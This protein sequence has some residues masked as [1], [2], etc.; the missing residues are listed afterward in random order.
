[1]SWIN[2]S[3]VYYVSVET[4]NKL[5]F[6]T[7]LSKTQ[8]I[9]KVVEKNNLSE[10]VTLHLHTNKVIEKRTKVLAPGLLRIESEPINTYFKNNRS[11]HRDY[12][13]VIKEHVETLQDLLKH[14]RALNSTY[15]N[16]YYAC[17]FV[18]R[19]QELLVY[20]SASCPFSQNGNEKWAPRTSLKKNNKPYVDTSGINKTV[21][22]NTQQSVEKQTTQKTGNTF[23]TST[24]RVSYTN[25]SGLQP[26]RNTKNDGIPRPSS[27]SEKNKVEAQHRESKSHGSNLYIISLNDMMKSSPI[28]LLSK[29]SK[30]KFWLWHHRLSR[31]NFD[32]INQLAKE[33]RVRARTPQQNGV[34]KRRNRTLVEAA[35][36]MLIFSKSLLFLWAEVVVTACYTQN[37]SLIH[38]RYNK[39]L[40]E[41][42]RERKPYLKYLHVFGALC[43]PTNDS[44]DLSKLKPEADAG[45]FI[46]YSPSTKAYRIYNKRTQMIME[47]I[48]TAS[49]SAKPP[50]K[51]D[52]DLPMFDEYFKHSPSAVSTTV[53]AATLLPPDTA[54]ASS[55]TTIDQDSLSLSATPITKTTVTPLHSTNVNEPN[56]KDAKF[57]SDTF[58]NPFA[59]SVTN[60]VESSS[61]IVDTSNMH[62]FQQ[63]QTYIRRWT[64]DHPLVTIIGQ[65]F[66]LNK[67]S[68]V[69][70]KPHTPRSCLRWKPT[71]RIFKTVGL[72]WI[73]TGKMF[74]DSTT[75]V[76]SEPPNG[77]N[78]D[79]SNPYE[80]DQTFYFSACTFNSS[81]DT[82]VTAPV[83]VVS[84]STHSLTSVDQDALLP[85]TSQPS[86]VSPS[87]VN[88]TSAEEADH[89]IEVVHMGDNLEKRNPITEPSF[90]ESSSHN[91]YKEALEESCWIEVMQEELP[92]FEHELGGGVLKNKARLVA[93]G[94]R[95]KEG[96]DFEESFAPVARLEAIR[97]I[98]AFAAH[99]NMIVF[100]MDV[101]TT[102][103]NGVIRE[104]VYVSQPDG[105]V[106][107]KN[108][109]HV[110]K[111]KKALYGLK[112]AP[113]ACK[114]VDTPMV[115]KYK[116]DEDLKGKAVDPTR[117]CGMISTLMYLTSSRPDLVF[118]VC[119]CARSDDEVQ[120][121]SSDEENKAD[122]NK[123]D[124]EVTLKHDPTAQRTPL[125][126]IDI[127]MV[128]EKTT[129][130]PTPPITTDASSIIIVFPEIN[131]LNA[132]Q[133]RVAKL[134]HDGGED[135]E[136][137]WGTV[138][139]REKFN[140]GCIN[141]SLAVLAS[142]QSQVHTVVDNYLGSKLDD[143]L[144]KVLQRHTADLIQRRSMK[145]VPESNKNPEFE[146][147]PEEILKIKKEHAEKQ[148]MPK[149]KIRSTDKAALKEYDQ[150][151]ALFQT[152]Y[153]NKTFNRIPANHAL[154]HALMEALMADEKA[155]AKGVA[156]TVKDHKRKRD[157]DY[158]DDNDEDPSAG[159]NQDKTTKR[160]RTKKS[161][162]AKKT[163]TTKETF[164]G[165]APT[166]ST[167]TGKS[168][169]TKEPVKELISEVSMDDTTHYEGEDMAHDN[170]QAKD[171]F[172]Q[173]PRHPTPDP[174]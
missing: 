104:E 13:K 4:S 117:Y 111:L 120:D 22:N 12:L 49:T 93:R 112:Q 71:G 124:A 147:S 8:F 66:S 60:F 108:P 6:V 113:R 166:K 91:T 130:I 17:K 16:L 59:P 89:D 125:I 84:T 25:A 29:A 153:D 20:V 81:A 106:D 86:Q 76:D 72:Q 32:T 26:K 101:K 54:D 41:F 87:H 30:T 136:Q 33:G 95:Q 79:I 24:R 167:K 51:N 127:P 27:R 169:T 1:M 152:M 168:A 47:T 40:Y 132:V 107:G 133:L 99:M 38:T 102:F 165:K 161:E 159:P 139:W 34:V 110:Y 68:T 75:K 5:Y 138:H 105:F 67:S 77:S 149:Y 121:V 126:D 173:A 158:D 92:E 48:H 146:K 46:G 90:K 122:E 163:S 50:S 148:K 155:M 142:L 100:Q 36:S 44:E 37:R 80:Y 143:S 171:W 65:M 119:M 160:R 52:L 28:C 96:I 151:S 3:H 9:P 94:Y 61:R 10:T 157:G 74:I 140:S 109:N 73:P 7:P 131:A 170:D 31:L 172:I 141:E 116:L 128:T 174:K 82:E 23:L 114:Q 98:I 43:Y 56:N 78:D 144:Y 2:A 15:E 162:S 103:L 42:L 97:I 118:V 135:N 156:D 164:K 19:I 145:H 57:D 35:H 150:K 39:T 83:L 63:P 18:Q 21:V 53:S 88:S 129:S 70:E 123:A 115:E 14:A 64:K 134:E 45:V 69:H 62:T 11:V 85:S 58:T 55:S 137:W 154:Y